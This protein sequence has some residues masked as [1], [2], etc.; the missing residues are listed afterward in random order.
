VRRGTGSASSA[1]SVAFFFWAV[2][3]RLGVDEVVHVLLGLEAGHDDLADELVRQVFACASSVVGRRRRMYGRMRS[4]RFSSDR[5]T[6]MN[7]ST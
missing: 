6:S 2:E 7:S 3:V 1:S 5:Q 4:I